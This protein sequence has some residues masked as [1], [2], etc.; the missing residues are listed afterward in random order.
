M[1]LFTN[2]NCPAHL[3]FFFSIQYNHSEGKARRFE[4]DSTLKVSTVREKSRPSEKNLDCPRKI[5]TVREKSRPSEKSLNRPRKI[6]FVGQ[7]SRPSDKNIDRPT[8][9]WTVRE[10]LDRFCPKWLSI[11]GPTISMG[12]NVVVSDIENIEFTR[13]SCLLPIL[14]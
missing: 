11:L 6:S 4:G 2:I 3:S 14:L 1:L 5:S 9:I 8:K 7:K 10:K 12:L 13:L